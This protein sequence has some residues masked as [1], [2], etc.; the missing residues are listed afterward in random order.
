MET[1][2]SGTW[3]QNMQSPSKPK[4]ALF[5]SNN[6][7]AT[8]IVDSYNFNLSRAEIV[9]HTPNQRAA[10][11]HCHCPGDFR[12]SYINVK[13]LMSEQAGF[14]FLTGQQNMPNTNMYLHM[15]ACIMVWNATQTGMA[16]CC[17]NG[18]E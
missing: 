10:V 13:I 15:C 9:E 1:K 11:V 12:R 2:Q 8:L 5:W 7:M 16:R 6:C 3:Q 18:T 14:Q 17:S 4:E